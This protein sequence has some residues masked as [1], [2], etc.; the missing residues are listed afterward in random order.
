MKK[1]NL[2]EN[3]IKLFEQNKAEIE[4]KEAGTFTGSL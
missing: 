2:F 3:K 1:L 4:I